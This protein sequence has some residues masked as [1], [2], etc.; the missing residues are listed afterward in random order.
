MAYEHAVTNGRDAA[1]KSNSFPGQLQSRTWCPARLAA[2]AWRTK[3][4]PG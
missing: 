1:T 3:A 4:L 2:A